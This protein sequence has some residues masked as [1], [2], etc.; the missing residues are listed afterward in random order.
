MKR[1]AKER[2][3][4]TDRDMKAKWEGLIVITEGVDDDDEEG[5]RR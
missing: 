4:T 3:I 1:E 2:K 5:E